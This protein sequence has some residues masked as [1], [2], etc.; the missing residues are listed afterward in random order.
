MLICLIII[1]RFYPINA[2]TKMDGIIQTTVYAI[3]G[4]IVYFVIIYKSGI[5]NRL[6]KNLKR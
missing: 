4:M 6:L 3:I 1:S 5:L 2:I